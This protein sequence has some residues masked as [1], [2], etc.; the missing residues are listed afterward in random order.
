MGTAGQFPASGQN[1]PLPSHLR[2]Q[3]YWEGWPMEGV[4]SGGVVLG[5]CGFWRVWLGRVR[6]WGDSQVL[7][8][9]FQGWSSWRLSLPCRGLILPGFSLECLGRHT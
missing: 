4:A 2:L 1:G 8:P 3:I 7:S 6:P 9:P 5:G